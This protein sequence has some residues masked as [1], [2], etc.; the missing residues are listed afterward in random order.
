MPEFMTLDYPTAQWL[1]SIVVGV[2]LT[3]AYSVIAHHLQHRNKSVFYVPYFFWVVEIVVAL[4]MTWFASPHGY[5]LAAG[6]KVG[7][8]SRVFIDSLFIIIVLYALPS[9]ERLSREEVNLKNFYYETKLIRP[10][11]MMAYNVA[12]LTYTFVFSSTPSMQTA[13]L[14]SMV[15]SL[16]VQFLLI[17]LDNQ[18]FLSFLHLVSIIA[19]LSFLLV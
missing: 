11:M 3:K 1:I 8:V 5:G 6:N 12:G 16:I 17:K 13:A 14:G 9:D 7:F 15:S 4:V 2:C 18:Y 19:A 10:L